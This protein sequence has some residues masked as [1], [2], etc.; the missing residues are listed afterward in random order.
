MKNY[1]TRQKAL[2]IA[3]A[4][5]ILFF[6]GGCALDT[7]EDFGGDIAGA[8]TSGGHTAPKNVSADYRS[9]TSALVSWDAVDGA[10]EYR[11]YMSLTAKGVY[12]KLTTDPYTYSSIT[13]NKLSA[14]IAYY[15][16]ITAVFP[17]GKE[18]PF[19]ASA[20]VTL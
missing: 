14:G 18:S 2:I 6:F 5:L 7:D 1:G 4:A 15:F 10:T 8:Q 20:S 11:I 16:K 17:G 13:V 19:S 3:F 9:Y 12:E